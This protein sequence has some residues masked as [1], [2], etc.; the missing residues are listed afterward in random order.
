MPVPACLPA[1]ALS[2][3]PNEHFRSIDITCPEALLTR[4]DRSL[5]VTSPPAIPKS[6]HDPSGTN[7]DSQSPG[8]FRLESLL[9]E[10]LIDEFDPGRGMV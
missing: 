4:A 1:G 6:G 9:F 5:P 8:P 3:G 7:R 2:N 10:D